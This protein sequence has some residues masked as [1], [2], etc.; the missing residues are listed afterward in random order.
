MYLVKLKTFYAF[1]DERCRIS[2]LK[3]H[4]VR[5]FIS[6][7]RHVISLSIIKNF[8]RIIEMQLKMFPYLC[9]ILSNINEVAL[10]LT[11]IIIISTAL[12][13]HLLFRCKSPLKISAGGGC[14]LHTA[15]CTI[16][17][18]LYHAW[19]RSAC[20]C[21]KTQEE[22]RRIATYKSYNNLI[23]PAQSSRSEL[24]NSSM[25]GLWLA[26]KCFCGGDRSDLFV[27]SGLS[28]GS[29]GGSAAEF[30]SGEGGLPTRFYRLSIT[31]E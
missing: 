21:V 11:N 8:W 26:G 31:S 6:L 24:L 12:T 17:L 18:H 19:S 7:T 5:Q 1:V 2:Q 9:T 16:K 22:T 30:M 20:I 25:L 23:D 29:L 10:Q 27:A 15:L 13:Q 4:Q 14:N 3:K 28:N